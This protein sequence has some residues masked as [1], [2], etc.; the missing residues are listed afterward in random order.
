MFCSVWPR[1]WPLVKE[2]SRAFWD[3][4]TAMWKTP[5]GGAHNTRLHS[6]C[7]PEGL[8]RNQNH[9]FFGGFLRRRL[10]RDFSVQGPKVVHQIP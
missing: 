3:S 8:S 9:V 10:G 6:L 5:E 2:T 1:D 7:I 4:P